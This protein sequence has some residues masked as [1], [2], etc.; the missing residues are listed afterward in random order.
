MKS[1]MILLASITLL[2]L[3]GCKTKQTGDVARDAILDLKA[4]ITATVTDQDRAQEMLTVVEKLEA[5]VAA[6]KD[7]ILTLRGDIVKANADYNVPDEKIEAL[8]GELTLQIRKLFDTFRDR[9]L[10]LRALCSADEWES[11]IAD[12]DSSVNFTFKGGLE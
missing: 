12:D 8:Y 6:I 2:G 3:G 11:I 9:C 7:K 4:D 1:I 10:E 5:D